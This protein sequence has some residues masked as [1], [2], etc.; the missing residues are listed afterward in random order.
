MR[1]RVHER[2][3]WP[4][5]WLANLKHSALKSAFIYCIKVA[6]S[7]WFTTNCQRSKE[8]SH[9]LLLSDEI[10]MQLKRRTMFYTREFMA[11]W[12]DQVTKQV[13]D[14]SSFSNSNSQ[15]YYKPH[16]D[17]VSKNVKKTP[18]L[19]SYSFARLLLKKHFHIQ[20][21]L[22]GSIPQITVLVKI[23]P[24]V[25]QNWTIRL[26]FTN[27]RHYRRHPTTLL[28]MLKHVQL[29]RFQFHQFLRPT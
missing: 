17:W 28:W 14:G 5:L 20:N 3:G 15:S 11:S 29:K 23:T 18:R 27:V 4:N 16:S 7:K 21:A 10:L 25:C 22:K 19:Y 12:N 24:Y 9:L 2:T 8:P 13:T 1:N 6:C 26:Q